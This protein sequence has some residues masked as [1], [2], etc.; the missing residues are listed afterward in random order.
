MRPPPVQ[1]PA[2]SPTAVDVVRIAR[3]L[4]VELGVL[5]T[6]TSAS[7]QHD[8][9][10]ALLWTA[11][12]VP[13]A[14]SAAALARARDL[15]AGELPSGD[16]GAPG[17]LTSEAQAL[18]AGAVLCGDPADAAAQS[19]LVRA[20]MADATRV[21]RAA[22]DA[23]GMAAPRVTPGDELVAAVYGLLREASDEGPWALVAC[24]CS[25]LP[26]AARFAL[27]DGARRHVPRLETRAPLSELAV[28]WPP[29]NTRWLPVAWDGAGATLTRVAAVLPSQPGQLEL[30][31]GGAV[32]D[33]ASA[34]RAARRAIYRDETAPRLRLETWR[35]RLREHPL[36]RPLLDRVSLPGDTPGADDVTV[37]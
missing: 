31:V 3:A 14:W 23:W 4:D 17:G 29:A 2:P 16:H 25:S 32:L 20:M 10:S 15:L 13:E 8:G 11:T 24:L 36:A 28:G 22:I 34:S 19:A 35:A 5:G 21:R 1:H 18:L 12:F 6:Q 9:A 30:P 37:H 26:D 33:T 7:A 27:Y